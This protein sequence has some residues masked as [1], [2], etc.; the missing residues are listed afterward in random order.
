MYILNFIVLV[1]INYGHI[2]ASQVYKQ[3]TKIKIAFNESLVQ[4][5]L[6]LVPSTYRFLDAL[7]KVTSHPS[8][9]YVI[10]TWH[11]NLLVGVN[12]NAKSSRS[13]Y[14]STGGIKLS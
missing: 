12:P 3:K 1:Q 4:W 2:Y 11:P 13:S 5:L 9:I 7:G 6:G 8:I 10:L 14:S